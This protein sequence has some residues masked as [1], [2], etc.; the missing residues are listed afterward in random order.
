M[1]LASP[2]ALPIIGGKPGDI[3]PGTLNEQGGP[4]SMESALPPTNEH[5]DCDKPSK[6]GEHP[7]LPVPIRDITDGSVTIMSEITESNMHNDESRANGGYAWD[8]GKNWD[9]AAR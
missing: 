6:P 5:D 3:T 1:S 2:G 9:I 8:N 7:V 4:D